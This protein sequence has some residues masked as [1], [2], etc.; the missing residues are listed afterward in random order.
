MKTWLQTFSNQKTFFSKQ[1]YFHWYNSECSFPTQIMKCGWSW[2]TMVVERIWRI[3]IVGNA[4]W[5]RVMKKFCNSSVTNGIKNAWISKFTFDF[6]TERDGL[7]GYF[8]LQ[9]IEKGLISQMCSE[10]LFMKASSWKLFIFC[11][12]V[13]KFYTFSWNCSYSSWFY[14]KILIFSAKSDQI[15]Q[16][17]VCGWEC[18]CVCVCVTSAS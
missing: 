2:R 16:K 13:T 9:M 8:W 12:R 4:H 14:Q 17:R 6:F 18:G 3:I 10:F 15:S 1:Y 11:I 5:I 7:N